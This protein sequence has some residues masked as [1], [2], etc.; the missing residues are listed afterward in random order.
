MKISYSKCNILIIGNSHTS[1]HTFSLGNIPLEQVDSI[2]DLGITIDSKLRFKNHINEITS[3]ANQRAALVRRCFL[4][5]NA[6][7]LVLAF[8][9]HIRPLL[10]YASTTWSPSYIGLIHQL[11]SVQ[12]NF[13]KK[14]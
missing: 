1:T 2:R 3:K 11:E 13:T 7:N 9:T 12:R 14:S 5:R 8:K 10:E 4:S 6:T